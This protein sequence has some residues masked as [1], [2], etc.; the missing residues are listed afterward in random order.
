[1]QILIAGFHRSGTSVLSQLLHSAGLF[2]GDDLLGAMPSNPYGHFE[3]REV[4][5]LHRAVLERHGT[6]WQW[7][8]EVP[9]HIG[10]DHWSQMR[11]YVRRRDVRHGTWGFKDPRVCLFL[12]AWKHLMPDARTVVVYRDP[13]DSVRSLESRQAGNLL[14]GEGRAADHRRF[15]TEPDH[16]L[17][18]WLTYN[19]ALVRYVRAHPDD[20]L[21]L[22]FTDL[23]SGAPI[24]ERVNARFGADLDVVETPSVFDP[25][26]ANRRQAP[27]RV[28]DDEVASRV[29]AT[30]DALE[31]LTERTAVR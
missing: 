19:Q 9:F 17:R 30:W 29:R 22:P 11:Q 31:Q 2:L 6:D 21:V 15:F 13:G 4:L 24:V 27:Q 26:V 16:G 10:A 25:T 7:D 8:A 18:L 1:M 28:V 14:R 20:C 23:M 3:D 12:P 5:R